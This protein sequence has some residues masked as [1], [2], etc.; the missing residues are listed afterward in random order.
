MLA[1]APFQLL[2]DASSP[3]LVVVIT[4][5]QFRADYL[6]RFRPHFVPG[7]IK[8]LLE[9]GAN[10]IDCRYQHA[11]TKTACGHAVVL[12]GVHANVHGIINNAWVDRATMKRVNCVDDDAVEILGRAEQTGGARLPGA[13]IPLGASPRRLLATTVGDELK[14]SRSGRSKVIGISSKDRSAILLAGKL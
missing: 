10:F 6:A 2:A 5:D 1:I 12:T 4:V 13:L 11:V 8:L 3:S 7:G 9:Q 14:L